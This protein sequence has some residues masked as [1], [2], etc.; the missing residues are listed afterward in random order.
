MAGADISGR[1]LDLDAFYWRSNTKMLGA[2]WP[3][4]RAVIIR[5]LRS[6][7]TLYCL[8]SMILPLYV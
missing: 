7:E 1:V 4:V 2:V 3:T 6:G 5:V 8:V